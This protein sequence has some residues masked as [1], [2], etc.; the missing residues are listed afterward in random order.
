MDQ[1]TKENDEKKTVNLLN[2]DVLGN[3][4]GLFYPQTNL[5]IEFSAD[6][7]TLQINCEELSKGGFKIAI[8]NPPSQSQQNQS[9]QVEY[10][11]G[12]VFSGTVEWYKIDKTISIL[13]VSKIGFGAEYIKKGNDDVVNVA[14]L[15][16]A[17]LNISPL[18]ISVNEAGIGVTLS[19]P[20]DVNFYLSGI[21]ISFKN[22][23]LSIGGGLSATVA[24]NNKGEII[25]EKGKPVYDYSGMISIRFKEIGLT[26]FGKYSKVVKIDPPETGDP[27]LCAC[28]SLLAPIGGIPPFFVKGIAG[29]FGYNERLELPSIEDVNNYFL[30][31]ALDK[32][33]DKDTDPKKALEKIVPEKGQFFLTAGLKFTTFELL[34]GCMLV[35]VSF[36]NDFELGLLGC[37]DISIPPKT[38]I[39]IAYA[40]L[41]LIASVKPSEGVFS[42]AAQ[43]TNESYILSKNCKLTGGFAA[44]AWFGD[45]IHSGDFVI[46]LGGYAPSYPKPEH[47][48]T[49]PR[50][51]VN[52]KVDDNININGEMYFAVTPSNLMAGGKLCATY[53][54]GN[55][56]AW[57]N[58]YADI[59]MYWKPFKYDITVGASIGVS[60]TVDLLF[61]EKTFSIE[62]SADLRLWGP[63]LQGTV[64]ISWYIISFTISFGGD[65]KPE[66]DFSWE[67]FKATFLT[68]DVLSISI[69][70]IVGKNLN[71]GNKEDIDLVSPHELGITF[72]SKIPMNW[73]DNGNDKGVHVRPV[74]N[75]N[76]SDCLLK[77]INFSTII[78]DTHGNDVTN[79]FDEEK[80]KQKLP[81]ALWGARTCTGSLVELFVGK[82]LKLKKSTATDLKNQFPS[83]ENLWIRLE[84][85][86]IDKLISEFFG[87][88][89]DKTLNLSQE[90]D[91]IQKL[92]DDESTLAENRDSYLKGLGLIGEKDH[93]DI[94]DFV[95]NAKSW[96][97]EEIK[98][99]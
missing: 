43:L 56:K 52:W 60:Y 20:I 50:L 18:T 14:V 27:S 82:K 51:G 6:E 16:D 29:G 58:A 91:P 65:N 89:N 62:L 39:P 11:S 31:K 92:I 79:K 61:V 80:I 96:L 75:A 86:N 33:Y 67:K 42:V 68:E 34:E 38:D 1:F 97:S 95:Q 41:A 54:L 57:F 44:C 81:A 99:F 70:G 40:Q 30:I 45:N 64:H 12:P 48:P 76:T 66:E 49:V 94:S 3:L 63:E 83:V 53:T 21:G 7:S 26:A 28:F 4:L 32:G 10:S 77:T 88:G 35:T 46:S 84:D 25:I 5:D 36:G 69:D 9:N 87:F 59:L 22:E 24:K 19:D 8:S 55:L 72:M 73:D 74:E 47:Y 90:E 98:M 93:I 15:L 2:M 85:Q 37:A 13:K 23:V 78:T 71:T 17:S